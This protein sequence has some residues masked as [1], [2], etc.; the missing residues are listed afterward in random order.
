MLPATN[1]TFSVSM[2]VREF[3]SLVDGLTAFARARMGVPA[4][5]ASEIAQ[6]VLARFL[7]GRYDVKSELAWLRKAVARECADYH[8]KLSRSEVYMGTAAE[9]PD[10]GRDPIP[11]I[12][13]ELL[14]KRVVAEL[15]ARSG[16]VL[17][18]HYLLGF[19]AAEVGERLGISASYAE[20]LISKGLAEAKAL[21]CTKKRE[22][23]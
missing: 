6:T 10:R 15:P 4:P 14:A 17:R 5:V 3:R 23:R 21:L 8:S 19:T 12:H 7:S 9:L 18:L 2:E 22:P 16:E 13:S 1:G 20:N 11:Q